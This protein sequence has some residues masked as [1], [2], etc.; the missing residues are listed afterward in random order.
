VSGGGGGGP[1]AFDVPCLKFGTLAG[2]SSAWTIEAFV[3]TLELCH[4]SDF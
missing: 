3:F 2:G 1:W 4:I